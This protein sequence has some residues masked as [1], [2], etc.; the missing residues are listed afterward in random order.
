MKTKTILILCCVIILGIIGI[1]SSS[2]GIQFYNK[3][4][5]K[6]NKSSLMKNNKIFLIVLL[7]VSIVLTISTVIYGFKTAKKPKIQNMNYIPTH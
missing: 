5:E 4:S 3:C 7:V 6:L 2:I 1:A